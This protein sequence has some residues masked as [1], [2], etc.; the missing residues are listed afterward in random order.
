[1]TRSFPTKRT[2]RPSIP[3]PLRS[4]FIASRSSPDVSS[5]LMTTSWRDQH[6]SG[7]T[8]GHLQGVTGCTLPGKFRNATQAV[9]RSRLEMAAVM[10]SAE[11]W[12]ASSTAGT[13]RGVRAREGRP[14]Q[15]WTPLKLEEGKKQNLGRE[16][17]VGRGKGQ[18]GCC[19]TPMGTRCAIQFACSA[20][21]TTHRSGE[22]GC[23]RTCHTCSTERSCRTCSANSQTSSRRRLHIASGELATCRWR[24]ATST[25]SLV[26]EV[27]LMQ[28]KRCRRPTRTKT[29][30]WTST[31]CGRSWPE[32]A[33]PSRTPWWPTSKPRCWA[34]MA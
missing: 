25:L 15:D 3:M 12:S 21:S 24:S 29:A 8:S 16:A 26:G 32:C 9:P 13:V 33:L 17:R 19:W 23:Q 1:M 34:R 18:A 7:V 4:I 30:A 5:T 2:F 31:S 11:Q 10:Q 27:C 28:S 6:G 14:A 20:S 22:F